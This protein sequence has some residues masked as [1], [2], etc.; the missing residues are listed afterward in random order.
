MQ[1]TSGVVSS[2]LL[3]CINSVGVYFGKSKDRIKETS[4]RGWALVIWQGGRL[5]NKLL[6]KQMALFARKGWS[7]FTKCNKSNKA[8]IR[9]WIEK[10]GNTSRGKAS[11]TIR[12]K[13]KVYF[14]WI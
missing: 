13:N 10:V 12:R 7:W 8:E 4:V 6:L 14:L 2:K 11:E 1:T 9:Q 5:D 3:N